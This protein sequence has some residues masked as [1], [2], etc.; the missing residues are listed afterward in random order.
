MVYLKIAHGKD[1][2]EQGQIQ[3]SGRAYSC[4]E[5]PPASQVERGRGCIAL[6]APKGCLEELA[7]R[8]GMQVE[9]NLG[10]AFKFQRVNSQNDLWAAHVMWTENGN[11]TWKILILAHHGTDVVIT[12]SHP[13][14]LSISFP[15]AMV[16]YPLSFQMA[17]TDCSSSSQASYRFDL[18]HEQYPARCR[19]RR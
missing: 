3:D 4:D 2:R 15:W 9:Q 11:Q 13:A 5:L 17:R 18:W 6:T 1:D 16:I 19:E 8:A 14:L 12:T 10:I 7:D